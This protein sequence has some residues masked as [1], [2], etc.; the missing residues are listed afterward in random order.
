MKSSKTDSKKVTKPFQSGAP[1]DENTVRNALKFFAILILSAFMTF[2]VC[3][4]TAFKS[5]FLR[6]LINAVIEGLILTIF[7]TKGMEKGTEG[8]ARGEILYQHLQKGREISA[9]EK[10]I[11]FHPL[12]GFV[13]GLLG[14]LIIFLIAVILAVTA[15]KQMTGAG[16]LP[17][18]ME[19]YLRRSEIGDALSGYSQ[20]SGMT[21]TDV[22][23]IV[24]R[25][26]MMPFITIAGAENRG[27]LL[28]LER[29]SP[30]LVLF[31]ALS[32][33]AGYLRGPEKRKQIHSEIA[34]N[35]RK[36]ISKEKKER[37]A[38]RDTVPKGPEQLN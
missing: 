25:I 13:I 26:S 18:W 16:V 4:M 22:A 11:P 28:L 31:P 8:V 19:T 9:G 12:K 14:S 15:T 23:R 34:V 36:R 27:L 5:N 35:N 32:Y 24:V 3:S 6:I 10:K 30:V 7:F 20:S 33:G 17:S 37:K 21:V 38:R 1:T 2:L 29:I